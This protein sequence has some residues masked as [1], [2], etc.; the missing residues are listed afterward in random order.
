MDKI[1]FDYNDWAVESKNH[2]VN[3]GDRPLEL[4]IPEDYIP[5]ISKEDLLL[6]SLPENMDS[7][8]DFKPFVNLTQ[9]NITLLEE[10]LK[11]AYVHKVLFLQHN[12]FVFCK[13]YILYAPYIIKLI[14][15][16]ELK[17]KPNKHFQKQNL[18]NEYNYKEFG[19][20][21]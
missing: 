3:Q 5:T 11:S 21:S 10:H 2:R 1:N 9:E 7:S 15:Y 6:A 8:D 13:K 18:P 16:Y 20:G 14:Q 4:T 12:T 19:N 17:I